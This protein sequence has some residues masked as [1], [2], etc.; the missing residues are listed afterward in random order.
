M[1]PIMSG[2]MPVVPSLLAATVAG[3]RAG[4]GAGRL[5]KKATVPPPEHGGNAGGVAARDA[6][7]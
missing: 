7:R 1:M 2:A 3:G 5:N 4:A 6:G